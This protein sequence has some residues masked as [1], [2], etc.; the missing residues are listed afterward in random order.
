MGFFSA[1]ST[2][3]WSHFGERH[4]RTAV[5]AIS[6]FGLFITFVIHVVHLRATE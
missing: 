2:G 5:L 6:T 3:W 1:L 4:G